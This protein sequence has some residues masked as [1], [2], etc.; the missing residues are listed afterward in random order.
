MSRVTYQ[1]LLSHRER[2]TVF[3]G[4]VC[5]SRPARYLQGPQIWDCYLPS[6]LVSSGSLQALELLLVVYRITTTFFFFLDGKVESMR[7]M[8]L[9]KGLYCN[10]KGENYFLLCTDEF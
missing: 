10:A 7:V 4:Q 1:M 8:S 3:L 6:G 5:I 9:F 2:Q